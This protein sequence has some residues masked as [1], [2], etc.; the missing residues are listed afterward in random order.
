[1]DERIIW[2]WLATCPISDTSR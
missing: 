1:M 2:H